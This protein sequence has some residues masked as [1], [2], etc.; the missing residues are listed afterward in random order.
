MTPGV[1]PRTARSCRCPV[2]GPSSPTP[3]TLAA[4]RRSATATPPCRSAPA[5]PSASPS[6]GWAS[7]RACRACATCASSRSRTTP[8]TRSARRCDV[9]LFEAGEQVDITGVSKGKGF[10][11]TIKRHHFRRGPET[12]GS[13]SHRAARA[14]SAAARPPARCSRGPAWP[15]TWATTGSPSRRRPSCASTPSATCCSSRAPCPAPATRCVL[16]RKA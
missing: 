16:V 12:H 10:S 15:A 11:G 8:P 1:Q 6:P 4:D 14:R 7:S 5:P 13:D 9:D 3:V 2:R